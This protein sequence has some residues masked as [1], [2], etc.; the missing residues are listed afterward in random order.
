MVTNH[1]FTVLLFTTSLSMLECKLRVVKSSLSAAK[2]VARLNRRP[3]HSRKHSKDGTIKN[4]FLQLYYNRSLVWAV[5]TTAETNTACRVDVVTAA[6]ASY[7]NFN[8]T[9]YWEDKKI[10]KP[11][12]G[13]LV[14][15][16]MFSDKSWK[17]MLLHGHDATISWEEELIS[18]DDSKVCGAFYVRPQFGHFF[19]CCQARG[20]SCV[21]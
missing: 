2:S 15:L 17:W 19:S 3:Y 13:T 5:N 1:L 21:C 16:S 7:V 9:Y 4:I 6:N 18:V 12:E 20:M 10:V 11:L 14:V 8:R